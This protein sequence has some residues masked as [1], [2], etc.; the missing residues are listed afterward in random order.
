MKPGPKWTSGIPLHQKN[1]NR[2]S[3]QEY[4]QQ[5]KRSVTF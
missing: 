3:Q 5:G 1:V 2:C 4:E